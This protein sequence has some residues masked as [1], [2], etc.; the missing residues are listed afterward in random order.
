MTAE[1]VSRE[2]AIEGGVPLRGRLRVPGDKSLSHR[3]LIFAA[4]AHGRSSIT[5]LG[6][7]DDVERTRQVVEALGARSRTD[8]GVVSVDGPGPAGLTAPEEEL[9]CGNSGTTMRLTAGLVAGCDFETVL[10][11]D[12]SLRLRPMA[13]IIEPL[14][15]LGADVEGRENDTLAPLRIRGGD[16]SGTRVV[17]DVASAQVT[18]AV[19]LAALQATG[20]TEIV[21]P[22]PSRDHTYRMLSALDAP[23]HRSAER[24]VVE[25]GE[26][27]PFEFEV[28]GDPSSA[29]FFVVAATLIAGSELIVDSI[30]ANPLRLGFVDVLRRMGASIDVHINETRLGEPVAD[31]S[32]SSAPLRGTEIGGAEIAGVIDELPVLGVAAAFADGPTLIRDAAELRAKESDRVATMVVLLTTLGVPVDERPDGLMIGDGEARP[33]AFSSHGDHRMGMAAAVAAATLPGRSTVSDW[34]AVGVSYPGFLSDLETLQST[35]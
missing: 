5:G 24:L 33:A 16:L 25:A 30:D 29:A 11:G 3:A 7:G 14:R 34:E 17:L 21:E 12:E 19:V 10:T 23:V 4:M 22:A 28:P 35:T 27:R 1:D 15:M 18:S 8:G 2:I 20:I 9:D 13:R 6:T 31:L 26:P 32:V